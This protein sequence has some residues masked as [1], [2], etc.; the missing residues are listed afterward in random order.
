MRE[1]GEG[2]VLR[3]AGNGLVR[4]YLASTAAGDNALV[5]DGSLDDH[6]G[7]V[8][9]ALYF[10]DELLRATAKNESARLGGWTPFEEVVPLAADLPFLKLFTGA[11]MLR[12]DVRAS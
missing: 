1:R 7:V 2:W 6:D 10:G 3:L 9:T 12:L 5:L 8:Q 11:Q 4:A